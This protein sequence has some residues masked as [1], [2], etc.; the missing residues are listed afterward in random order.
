MT[1]LKNSCCL[2]NDCKVVHISLA[3]IFSKDMLFCSTAAVH[4]VSRSSSKSP[5]PVGVDTPATFFHLIRAKHNG[6][7]NVVLRP[8]RNIV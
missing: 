3:H 4:L 2:N 5:R 6:R 8:P 1:G 7:H